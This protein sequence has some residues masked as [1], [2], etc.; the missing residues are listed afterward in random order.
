MARSSTL[1]FL[2]TEP[3]AGLVMTLAA[4]AALALANSPAAGLYFD[5]IDGRVPVGVGPFFVSL[6]VE[7]W[8]RDGLMAVFFLSAGLELK[9][10]VLRGEI[11]SPRRLAAPLLAG[12]AGMVGPAV[13]YLLVNLGPGGDLRGWTVPTPTDAAFALG[14]LALVAPR[15]PRALRLFL[16]TL[17]VADDVGAIALIGVLYSHGIHWRALALALAVLAVMLLLARRRRP[18]RLAFIA[19]FVLV[20]AL[21]INSGISTS[22]A[23]FA[24]AMAV[25]VDRRS[26]DGE[27]LLRAYQAALQPYVAYL[28]LPL[29]AFVSAGIALSAHPPG[30]WFSRPVWGVALGLTLGKP[31]G[32]FGMVFLSSALKI[33]RKP[34]GA[35][36][37]EMLG[38]ALL[39]GVGFDL[40]FFLCGLALPADQQPQ[41][42]LAVMAGSALSLAAG[43]AVLARRQW[44]RDQ[45]GGA[46]VFAD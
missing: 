26:R 31:L 28:V 14:S 44:V 16:L 19:G 13:I 3:G 11:S 17:A 30:G 7:A 40:S 1:A 21:T 42:R 46:D 45:R 15:L 29:F 41:V 10:E 20:V 39:C 37:S 22:V 5:F 8:V 2:K 34:M 23:A 33:G 4:L 25:P 18:P 32:V 38:V 9:Y 27:S 35:T 24:C 12:A 6:S 43:S 36:W